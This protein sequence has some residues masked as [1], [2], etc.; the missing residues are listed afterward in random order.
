MAARRDPAFLKDLADS[1]EQ[2][3]KAEGVRV[4]AVQTSAEFREG[5]DRQFN[6]LM[7]FL[8]LMAI[9]IAVVGAIGL[10]GTM[11]MNVVERTRELGVLRAIGASDG[12]I[13]QIVVA[14]G[15]LI[16]TI[17]WALAAILAIP[18]SR[19]LSDSMGMAFVST[20]LPP[21]FSVAGVALWLGIVLVLPA[22]PAPSRPGKP[23][24]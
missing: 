9:L 18:I 15:V 14:E 4:S 20:P 13:Q 6:V 8:H 12:A 17:S 7:A 21:A 11:S 24:A 1:L 3:F 16:G 10:M 22:W 19:L 2:R 5:L 23:H